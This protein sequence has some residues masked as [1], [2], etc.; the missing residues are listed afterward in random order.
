M[1]RRQEPWTG[2]DTA[3]SVAVVVMMLLATAACTGNL[4]IADMGAYA[5]TAQ[6]WAGPVALGASGALAGIGVLLVVVRHLRVWLVAAARALYLY[7]RR[8]ARVMTDLG[9]TVTRPSGVQVPRVMSVH[10][11]DG[12]DI[13]RVRL[14]PGQGAVAFHEASAALAAEFGARSAVVRL[15]EVAHRDITI[16]F[17]RRPKPR[18]APLALPAPVAP[19]IPI[20]LPVQQQ[21]RKQQQRTGHQAGPALGIRV[22]GIRLQ[23]VWASVQRTR[24][25]GARVRLPLSQRYGLRGELRWATWATQA[26]APAGAN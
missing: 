9:L 26:T 7:R 11:V 21:P 10:R 19:V 23:I 20:G 1:S 25:D 22:S 15:G 4:S 13:V 2:K 24:H 12:E 16:T 3:E 8:W 18:R 17:D 14:V 5:Q 6:Q